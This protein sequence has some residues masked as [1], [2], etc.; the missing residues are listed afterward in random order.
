V[1]A[2]QSQISGPKPPGHIF[3]LSRRLPAVYPEG[4]ASFSPGL[5]G[6]S[7]PGKAFV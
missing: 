6:T 7:Y 3:F 2:A 1:L 5:R 4:I